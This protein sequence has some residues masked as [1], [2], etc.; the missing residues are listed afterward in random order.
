MLHEC[1]RY[2]SYSDSGI[3]SPPI[4][5]LSNEGFDL[6]FGTNVIGPFLFTKLL[7]PLLQAASSE[8]GDSRIIFTSSLGHAAMSKEVIIWETLK[9][10]ERGSPGNK[11]RRGLGPDKLYYQSK[12]VRHC[13]T[14]KSAMCF[15]LYTKC[16]PI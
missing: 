5:E 6:Q 3:M 8:T 11:K 1:R 12:C 2:I 16:T 14:P 7:L 15:A 13:S 4:D 10:G 9:P